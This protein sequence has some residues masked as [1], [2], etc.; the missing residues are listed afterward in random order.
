[1]VHP[2]WLAVGRAD[3]ISGTPER[4]LAVFGQIHRAVKAGIENARL[5]EALTQ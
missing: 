2:H 3:A 1:M 5:Q 4:I